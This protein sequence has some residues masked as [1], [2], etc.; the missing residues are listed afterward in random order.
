MTLFKGHVT[1]L[2]LDE[3]SR[4]LTAALNVNVFVTNRSINMR[5]RTN[6]Q[7]FAVNFAFQ[8]PFNH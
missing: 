2:V 1:L 7:I 3:L 5:E 8:L 4:H 6:I